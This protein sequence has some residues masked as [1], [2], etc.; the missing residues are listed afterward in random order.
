LF[1]TLDLVNKLAVKNFSSYLLDKH[2]NSS[3]LGNGA[4]KKSPI[5]ASGHMARSISGTS[6]K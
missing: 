3:E 5:G 2:R 4:W 6:S 1:P